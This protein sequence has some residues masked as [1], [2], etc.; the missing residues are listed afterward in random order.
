MTRT[1]TILA[2]CAVL[3]ACDR[4]PDASQ[5]HLAVAEYERGPHRGR[6]LRDGD[7]AIELTIFETGVP[8]EFRVYAYEGDK[9]LPPDAVTVSVEL[10][11]LGGTNDRFAFVPQQDFLRGDSEVIEPHS[12]D[13]TVRA[14]H[15]GKA[16]EWAFASYEG[17][18]RIDAAMAETMGL[19]T[20]VAGPAT[21]RTTVAVTGRIIADPDRSANVAARFPGTVRSV[22]VG[23]GDRVE[24]G[25]VLAEVQSRDSLQ[26]Y[27]VTAPLAGTVIARDAVV[28][29]QTG[30]APLFVIADLARV[31][32]EV[33][34]FPSQA[35][36]LV[37][38]QAILV[39]PQPDTTAVEAR[40]DRVS[41]ALDPVTQSR[42]ALVGLDNRAGLWTVG[43]F[44]QADLVVEDAEVPLAVR[45]DAL[46]AFRDFTV[47][48]ERVG[49]QYE[50]R[51]LELGRGDAEHVEVL[52]GL[53]PGARYAAANS[54]L[55]KADIEKAGASH[56][57]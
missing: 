13:V 50:V 6:L 29:E 9:P 44:V 49:D 32:L 19:G 48:F 14:T 1:L 24:R 28:G 42:H 46:Q 38:G 3:A 54:Y 15:D 39:A 33:D 2:L 11:R 53:A 27:A 52:G 51:M 47:V 10:G 20:E 43:Q 5:E 34:V 35:T 55:V 45:R 22:R 31:T 40:L 16:H 17:R 36:R 57:H 23:L 4:A 8:P 26:D 37:R 56:D 7:F 41:P 18:T 21:L 30:D 12:F 25:A